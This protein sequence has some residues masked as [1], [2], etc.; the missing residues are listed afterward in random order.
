MRTKAIALSIALMLVLG[1]IELG[2]AASLQAD[3][4][5]GWPAA[6]SRDSV[7]FGR[8]YGEWSAAWQ[9][10][11]DSMPAA[12]HPLFDT[13][14]CSEGQSGPVWF[15]GGKFCRNGDPTGS[16]QSAVRSCTVPAGKALYFPVVNFGCLDGEAQNGYCGNAGPFITQ[17]RAAIGDGID[18]TTKLKVTVDGKQIKGE[19][20]KPVDLKKDFRVQSPVYTAVLPADN[21]LE[22]IG[23]SQLVA[24]TYWGVDDGVYIMLMPLPKG[25]HTLNFKGSFPQFD[26]S[27][28]ITYNLTVE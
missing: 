8:T 5:F 2:A 1:S 25:H 4:I 28:D 23:E 14:L 27:L 3:S 20:L 15:L 6:Y 7:I 19:C 10:W 24:G 22:A 18:Q 16:A 13:A 17:M 21:L 11:A 12:A 9:Q 26:F